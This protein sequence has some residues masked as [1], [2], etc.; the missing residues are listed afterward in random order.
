M[1]GCCRFLTLFIHLRDSGL[2]ALCH[3]LVGLGLCWLLVCSRFHLELGNICLIAEDNHLEEAR[4]SLLDFL[5][6]ESHLIK[7]PIQQPDSF[8]LCHFALIQILQ[9][10]FMVLFPDKIA[11]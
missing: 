3:E 1:G 11:Q 8:F 7:L 6:I 9:E 10:Q 4:L 5:S 2:E